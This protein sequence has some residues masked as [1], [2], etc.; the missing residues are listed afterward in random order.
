MLSPESPGTAPPTGVPTN[1]ELL[2]ITGASGFLGRLVLDRLARHRGWKVVALKGTR[3]PLP[4]AIES[5]PIDDI[6]ALKPN[7]ILHLAA[8]TDTG[9]CERDPAA[10][11]TVNVALTQRIADVAT[12][13]GAKLL[14]TSTDLVFDGELAPYDE[15]APTQP[16][17]VYG[18][19]KA[20]AETIVLA[21]GGTITRLPLM[22]G[23]A[24][25]PRHSC[26]Q[27]ML[28]GM[29][30]AQAGTAPPLALFQDEWRTPI[31]ARFVA[32]VLV[33]RFQDFAAGEIYHLGGPE[34]LSRLD[35]GYL[36]ADAYEIPRD[37]ICGASRAEKAPGRAK[38]VSLDSTK[39][40]RRLR[41]V[42]ARFSTSL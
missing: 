30:A 12:R 13:V 23:P 24:L 37:T 42:P 9:A 7:A 35:M 3:S 40:W 25:G 29:R 32:Q 36:V 4:D 34:R 18:T 33:E 14:A 27:W 31:G 8:M 28:A 5:I 39:S 15:N 19:T 26:L 20:R 41:V 6:E 17:G 21:A 11:H 16:K 2:L 1:H 22:V 38:D 10:A